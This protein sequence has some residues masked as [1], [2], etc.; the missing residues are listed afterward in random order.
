MTTT[1]PASDTVTD[2]RVSPSVP[3]RFEVAVLPVSDVDRAKAFY[4]G[5]GWQLE[6]DVNFDAETRVVQLTPTGS[7][8]SIQ[9]GTN[10]TTATPC[11]GAVKNLYLIV[12]DIV[13]ARAD[14]ISHGADVSEIWHREPPT[15]LHVPGVDPERKSYNSFATFSDPDGNSWLLQELTVRLPGRVQLPD[16]E[17][18]AERL[19]ETSLQHERFDQAAPPHHWWDWYAA[20][21]VARANGATNDEA[22]ALADK[23]MAEAKGV[24]LAN[25]DAT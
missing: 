3:M 13:A 2:S 6:A 15:D 9:F 20:H 24:V 12:D 11:V 4:V 19:L 17:E 23:Y 14:L 21:M 18:L 5:L 16:V 22:S 8:A 7:P 25:K 1:Q 10:W